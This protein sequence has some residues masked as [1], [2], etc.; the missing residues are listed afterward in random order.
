MSASFSAPYS[1]SIDTGGP[2]RAHPFLFS[3]GTGGAAALTQNV[4]A[5]STID[6]V[7]SR[8]T[9][10]GY[11][12]GVNFTI[13][14]SAVAVPE[15]STLTLLGIGAVCSLGYGWRRRKQVKE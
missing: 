11:F 1:V 4:V 8:T 9:P 6:L 10:A 14:E 12:V 7:L 5:G 2:D 15:P 3:S 13:T